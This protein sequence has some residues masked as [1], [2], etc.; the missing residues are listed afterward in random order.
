[1]K[2][3]GC[4]L[5]LLALGTLCFSQNNSFFGNA[6]K[7][8]YSPSFTLFRPVPLADGNNQNNQNN[9]SDQSNQNNQSQS[10]FANSSQGVK[11]LRRGEIVFFGS[12]PF[13]VFFT[14]TFFELFRMGTHDW[15]QR[16]APWPFKSP[17]AVSMTNRE[18]AIMFTI[19]ASVSLTISI[20]DHL[21]VRHKRKTAALEE[22]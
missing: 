11:D 10:I 13:T 17:G 8:D 20:A 3:I 15:D 7:F 5:F 14:R 21:V 6:G 16:Y 1:L 18:I 19:A 2:R 22:D 12:L 9:Q 4:L